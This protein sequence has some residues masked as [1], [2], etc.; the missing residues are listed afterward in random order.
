MLNTVNLYFQKNTFNQTYE[1]STDCV[2][3]PISLCN[4]APR[5]HIFPIYDHVILIFLPHAAQITGKQ[6]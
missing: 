4:H 1:L 2:F 6:V 5:S 3:S